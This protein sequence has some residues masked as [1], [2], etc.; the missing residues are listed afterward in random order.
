MSEP[1]KSAA[2]RPAFFLV[3]SGAVL[4]G[5]TLACAQCHNHKSDPFSQKEYFQLLAFFDNGTY[6]I[7][8]GHPA[9]FVVEPEIDLPSEPQ[10]RAR[11]ELQVLFSAL[12]MQGSEDEA[13]ARQA[14]EAGMSIMLSGIHPPYAR[15][16]H[17]PPQLDRA[18][19]KLDRLQPAA[20]SQLV[21]ALAA[22][23]SH[24]GRMTAP[25]SELLRAVCAVLHCPLP[26]LY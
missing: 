16:G 6:R 24:D 4:L 23:I 2:S 14:Y 7:Q 1:R 25:E 15:L 17:W 5:T 19:T 13:A 3:C 12:A 20:K 8:G 26:P 21:E 10:R 11:D 18:L 9:S 22:A